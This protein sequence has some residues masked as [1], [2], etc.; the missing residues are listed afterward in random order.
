MQHNHQMV[1]EHAQPIDVQQ[2][3]VQGRVGIDPQAHP[4]A[5][6]GESGDD[7]IFC[8]MRRVSFIVVSNCKGDLGRCDVALPWLTRQ[9][10]SSVV[11]MSVLTS[12]PETARKITS[13]ASVYEGGETTKGNNQ[14]QAGRECSG[15]CVYT[16]Y[17]RAVCLGLGR[18]Y[19]RA[20]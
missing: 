15:V 6:H 17:G 2:I 9:T 16:P 1:D 3:A 5:A 20:V 8:T 4:I 11:R 19:S 18:Q 14:Q 12:V 7:C 10:S 13:N